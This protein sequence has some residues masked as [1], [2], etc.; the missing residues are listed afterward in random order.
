MNK[1]DKFGNYEAMSLIILLLLTKIFYTSTSVVVKAEGT[2]AWYVTLISCFVGVFFFFL[3]YLLM[4][5]FPGKNIMQIFEIVLGKV[6]GKII[7]I[8]FSA[9]LLYYAASNLREFVE[10]IKAYNLPYT[11][12]SVIIILFLGVSALIAYFGLEGIARVSKIVF[13]PILV[14]LSLIF[15]LAIPYYDSD[16]LKPYLG[17]SLQT[18]ITTGVL[19]SSAYQE[20]FV[21]A[22]IINSIHGLKSFKKVGYTSIIVAGVTFSL[23]YIFYLMS[24][25]YN[26]GSENLSGLFQLSRIIYFNR[27]VQRIESIFLFA[28]VI[29]SLITVSAAFYFAIS[30]YQNAFKIKNHRPIILPFVILAFIVTLL[31]KGI[32]EVIDVNILFIRQYSLFFVYLVP[33]LVLALAVIMRKRGDIKNV[34]KS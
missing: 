26:M 7:I 11:P 15:I 13:I 34:Q 22:I 24:F 19:R 3:L 28:W 33:V 16:Y 2:A 25:M 27:F 12:P 14:I 29:T 17:Y 31:P 21:L 8:C 4:K 32:S 1:I 18:T 20:F 5:R 30:M 9:Y 10:M 23:N 6:I